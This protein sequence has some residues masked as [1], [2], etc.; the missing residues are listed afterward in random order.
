[1]KNVLLLTTIAV[2][3]ITSINN[4]AQAQTT[5]D[6]DP[7]GE[8]YTVN[9]QQMHLHCEGTVSPTVILEA[10]VGGFTLNWLRVQ[11]DIAEFTRVC[12]YDR[13]GYG[14]SDPL[15]SEFEITQTV[16]NLHT[17]L[18]AA[19]VEPPYILA[20]HSF[21]GVI[22]RAYQQQHPDDVAAMLLI[23]TVHPNMAARIPF[24][25]EALELQLDALQ[26]LVVLTRF[27]AAQS[28]DIIF[29]VPDDVSEETARAFSAA[30][31]EPQFFDAS[32]AEAN[33]IIG[34]LTDLDLPST[35]GDI[36]LKVITHG[37]PREDG[38]LGAPLTRGRAALAEER[39]QQMQREMVTLSP[40]G[41]LIVAED[42]THVIQFDQPELIIGLVQQIVED[43]R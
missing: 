43:V 22:A 33:Y 28:E 6:F 37:I 41:E 13:I 29:P 15:N 5:D 11:P 8:I 24:Y 4:T 35:V 21:G 26:A 30:V 25:A 32:V 16:D 31:L 3:C 20:A 42:S 9:G 1:M 23:D 17:L 39:W 2:L 12:S 36:P 14:W 40:Q 19:Q 27:R 34:D 38:F 10:G 7:P 18:A